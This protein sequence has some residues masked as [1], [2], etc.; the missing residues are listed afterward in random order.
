[1][2]AENLMGPAKEGVDFTC[3]SRGTCTARNGAT[4]ADYEEVQ[5]QI[6]RFSSTLR[7]SPLVVDGALGNLTLSAAKKVAAY[8]KKATSG[9]IFLIL[10]YNF[11]NIFLKSATTRYLATFAEGFTQMARAVANKEGLTA[12]VIPAPIIPVKSPITIEPSLPTVEPDLAIVE[13]PTS[14]YLK[15]A[16]WGGVGVVLVAAWAIKTG[17]L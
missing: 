9:K 14:P 8:C 7:F 2:Y 16:L 17:R 6:N 1:M 4:R 3:S 11:A 5:K 15:W 13:E 12:R 10:H